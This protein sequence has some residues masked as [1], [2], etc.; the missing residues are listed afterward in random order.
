MN[1]ERKLSHQRPLLLVIRGRNLFPGDARTTRPS[2]IAWA[3]LFDSRASASNMGVVLFSATE[4]RSSRVCAISVSRARFAEKSARGAGGCAHADTTRPS[5][6]TRIR[7]ASTGAIVTPSRERTVRYAAD[8]LP[9]FVPLI[10]PTALPSAGSAIERAVMDAKE[11]VP[12]RT[13]RFHLAKDVA[14]FANHLG[15]NLIVGWGEDAAGC[16]SIERPLTPTEA[17]RT[18]KRYTEAVIQLCSPRPLIEFEEYPRG[19]GVV[20]AVAVFPS[21]DTPIGVEVACKKTK[22]QGYGGRAYVFPVRSGDGS[23]YLLPEQLA[24][25]MSPTRRRA[26][27][28]L[29]K[30]AKGE[31]VGLALHPAPGHGGGTLTGTLVDV[32]PEEGTVVFSYDGREI[33]VPLDVVYAVWKTS[34][35]WIV[36]A[37]GELGSGGHFSPTPPVS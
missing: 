12:S 18:R 19:R 5:D 32:R 23:D 31:R 2:T 36:A 8:V 16:L 17:K 7:R 29:S 9:Y 34:E 20:L 28:M 15:G 14:V 3:V 24:M 37:R 6:T 30:I 35:R 21:I 11:R 4:A 26:V 25:W 33:F 27:V 1:A 13:T 22:A 10:R